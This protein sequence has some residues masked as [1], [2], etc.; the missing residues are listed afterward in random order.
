MTAIV[1]TMKIFDNNI[2]NSQ[3][4]NSRKT[5]IKSN[6][7]L[8]LKKTHQGLNEP[9]NNVSKGLIAKKT[10]I[11][12]LLD[13]GSS[14]DLLFVRKGSQKYIPYMIRAAPQSWGLPMAPF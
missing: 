7:W 14:G 1:A 6:K 10:T 11:R 5:S 9:I 4:S 3:N 8:N 13:T 2:A 12:V